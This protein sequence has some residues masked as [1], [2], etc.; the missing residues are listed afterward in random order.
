MQGE[1][2]HRLLRDHARTFSLTLAL[3]PRRLRNPLSLG[4]L[5][6]RAADTVADS[7]SLTRRERRDFLRAVRDGIGNLPIGGFRTPC[8]P[9]PGTRELLGTLPELLH[10]LKTHPDRGELQPMLL[11][12]LEGQLF[13]QERFPSQV[14]L[15]PRE[16]HCY[17]LQVAG[18]VGRAWCLL[19]AKYGPGSITVDA[20]PMISKEEAYGCG[21]QMINILRDR[22]DDLRR[23]RIYLEASR[24]RE[25]IEEARRLL[26]EGESFLSALRPGRSLYASSLTLDLAHA[27]LGMMER[28]GFRSGVRIQRSEVRRILLFGALRLWLPRCANPA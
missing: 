21:L 16:L 7:E 12:I 22:E 20:G 14:P 24:V 1:L 17:C 10:L 15:D 6:A 3:L 11:A 2:I 4:Y 23:G 5:I 28:G 26:R 25:A 9:D 27:T 13:D 19:Q 18:S 8:L